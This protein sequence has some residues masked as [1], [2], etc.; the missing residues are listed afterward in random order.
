MSDI[1]IQDF[2]KDIGIILSK[3]YATFPRKVTLY[4][5]DIS[6]PDQVDEYGLH[7]ERHLSALSAVVWLQDQGYIQYETLVRQEAVDF[8]VLSEKSFLL[9]TTQS[10]ISLPNQ[11]QENLEALEKQQL[12]AYAMKQAL[13]NITLLRQ[14]LKSGSS[15]NIEQVVFHLLEQGN[16]RS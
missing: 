14:A 10:S 4:V 3:L 15:I 16:L 1:H 13:S 8:A 6:G 12:P 2:Y 7:S 9:L 5:E 11:L